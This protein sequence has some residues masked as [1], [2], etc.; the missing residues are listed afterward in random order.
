VKLTRRAQEVADLVALG[1]TNREIAERLFISER[2]VEWHLEQILNKLGF[3]SRSQVAAW[4][5]RSQTES[6]V[7]A[8]RT[9]P[10]GNLPSRFTSFV[11]RDADTSSLREVV[12]ANRLVTVTGPGGTGKTSLALRAAEELASGYPDGAWFCDLAPVA[13]AAL[14]G[15]AVAQ[16]VGLKRTTQDRLGAVR[17][18]LRDKSVLLILDNCEHLVA[19]ASAVARAI[20]EGCPDAHI[21]A[22]SRAALGVIGEA[23][24]R[25][26]PLDQKDA[27][28]LFG[29][30]AEATSP[31][32]RVDDANAESVAEICRRLD[33]VPL[34]IELVVPRLRVQSASELATAVLDPSWQ[35]ESDERHG[36]LHTLALWSYRL[37]TPE[38]QA[39][40]RQL[41]V[42]AGWFDA[43]DAAALMRAEV[44]PASVLLSALVEQSI[45]VYEYTAKGARY[46]LLETL[47]AF[48]LEQLAT[49]GDLK[50]A[51]RSHAERIVWLAERLDVM[52]N[53]RPTTPR[54]KMLAMVDDVRA[55][56][57]WLIEADP[58]R[59]AWLSFA[60]NQTWI[61]S[62]RALEALHWSERTLAAA[63]DQSAE[64]CW[65]LFAHASLLAELGR[66]EEARFWLAQGEAM[67]DMP[68]HAA[69]KALSV[70]TSALIR[71]ALGDHQDA[72]RLNQ[73][74]IK[75]FSRTGD[76][77][78]LSRA[79]NHT[80]MSMLFLGQAA[81][82]RQLAERALEILRRVNSERA[83]YVVDTLA[84]AN[85]LL[86]EL[87]E[88]KRNWIEVTEHGLDQ[89]W[90]QDV[91]LPGGLFGL[92][93]VAG[94]RGKNHLALRLHYCA[95][96]TMAEVGGIYAEPI[97]PREKEL[98][99][100]LEEEA[101][102]DAVAILR[103]ESEAL[104]PEK[105]L[106]LARAEV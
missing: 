26:R 60:M 41:G 35:Q 40:F 86:G 74:A 94:L 30:R 37:L 11:G 55:A 73:D 22:T 58:R 50:A 38:Q 10:R 48:A 92:A 29:Q 66:D 19:A 105:A 4:I 93:L 51:Q 52:L 76:E 54:A 31:G 61:W 91:N 81:E 13:E 100:R 64:R 12:K 24:Y 27:I 8:P 25:L 44:V 69:L 75:A 102:P 16:A 46:R 72:I 56:M 70:N 5:G 104:T 85:A 34:A 28:L 23:I 6:P 20:L 59:A 43:D 62:G 71:G 82:S 9:R 79:L 18:H 67:A 17:E 84:Q 53:A 83:I 77:Q 89:G 98:I 21:L 88:A 47:K 78:Q 42:F 101:G 33:G 45:L 95:Q 103:T 57:G 1:L 39:L 68:E 90:G 87:G 49:S 80:A 65:N 32:F 106:E 99:S 2:T 3:T 97:S 36:S 7:A 15:D 63:P 96:R 14:V